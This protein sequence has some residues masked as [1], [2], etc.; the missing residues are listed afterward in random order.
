MKNKIIKNKKGV[1]LTF[2]KIISILII[3]ALL[4]W[5]IFY[6]GGLKDSIASI[7]SRF[8]G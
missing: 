7:A 4:V 3:L 2:A 1:E 6:F 8:L 5:A